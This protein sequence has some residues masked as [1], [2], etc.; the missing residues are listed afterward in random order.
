MPVGPL[1]CNC[2]VTVLDCAEEHNQSTAA[3]AAAMAAGRDPAAAAQAA[4]R[5]V[6]LS[7]QD[8]LTLPAIG[9]AENDTTT[10]MRIFYG[11]GWRHVALQCLY[12]VPILATTSVNVMSEP[13]KKIKQFSDSIACFLRGVCLGGR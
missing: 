2:F 1:A 13:R 5:R 4:Q 8:A 12:P 11:A 6:W 7:P 10:V 9:C 3:A